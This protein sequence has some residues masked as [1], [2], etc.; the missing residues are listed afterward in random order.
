MFGDTFSSVLDTTVASLFGIITREH[1]TL[2]F[3]FAIEIQ[4][5][6]LLTLAYQ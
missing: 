1:C 3:T 5:D 2:K 4:I 6:K